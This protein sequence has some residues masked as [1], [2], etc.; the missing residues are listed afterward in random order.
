MKLPLVIEKLNQILAERGPETSVL[1]DFSDETFSQTWT[2]DLGYIDH[3]TLDGEP[4]VL[5]MASC[6]KEV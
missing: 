6:G 5:L 3:G 4:V 2:V 1:V